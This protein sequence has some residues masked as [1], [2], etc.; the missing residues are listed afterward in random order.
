MAGETF[1]QKMRFE[2]ID[3]EFFKLLAAHSAS[4]VVAAGCA[5]DAFSLKR[6]VAAV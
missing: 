2:E 4:T 6:R 1:E 5:A 3:F